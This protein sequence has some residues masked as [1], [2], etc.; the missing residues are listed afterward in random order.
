M[1]YKIAIVDDD[2]NIR[3]SMVM[4]FETEGFCVFEYNNGVDALDDLI[5]IDFDVII[6]DIKMPRMDGMELL[7]KLREKITTP[8]IFLTSKD[9]ELDELMG[10][11]IGADDYI[12]K[13]FSMRLL[14]ERVFALI[15][16]EK[17]KKTQ[18]EDNLNIVENKK[19][20][21]LSIND[22]TYEC[23]W[24][25]Q[26]IN[27]TVSE[28]MLLK[29][30]LEVPGKIKTRIEI[31][32]YINNENLTVADRAI[33]SHIRRLRS[34]FKKIDKNFSL[35]ESVYGAGYRFNVDI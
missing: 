4:A 19:L 29:S 27:L 30:L 2:K 18:S 35:I 21:H 17:I 33:D 22:S 12:T 14:I 31:L 15:R 3:A 26:K 10:L 7:K 25:G 5:N 28:Y 16:R 34:K 32:E 23:F 11:R 20:G 8:V 13:P 9:G 24:K 1:Q 6:L